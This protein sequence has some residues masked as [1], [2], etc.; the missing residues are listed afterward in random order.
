MKEQIKQMRE[1]SLEA[2]IKPY[3]EGG[4][5]GDPVTRTLGGIFYWLTV[6]K[7]LPVEIAGGA[8][9]MVFL[10]LLEEGP[11]K[12]NSTYGSAGDELDKAILQVASDMYEDKV[13]SGLYKKAATSK[14]PEIKRFIMS[15][16]YEAVPWFVK[17]FGVKYWKFRALKR[18]E[19][20]KKKAIKKQAEQA[21]KIKMGE[22]I[23]NGAA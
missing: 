15:C 10:K 3:Q 7:K 22:K 21:W 5:E 2:M 8:I 9:F 1:L 4:T 11:F 16:A 20:K 18:A 12:G 14:S 19:K 17:M 23:K 6:T 13:L